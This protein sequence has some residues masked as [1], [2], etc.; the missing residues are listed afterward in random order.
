MGQEKIIYVC[1]DAV[2]ETSEAVAR[3]AMRQF[4]AGEVKLKRYGHIKSEEEIAAIVKEAAATGGFI[5]FTLVQPELR[6]MMKEE[7]QR[8]G[9]RVVDVMGPMMQ[10]YIDTF[11]GFPKRQPGLL[12]AL[13]EDYF[14][15]IEA[16]EFAVKYDDGKD[17]RGL[18][19]AQ[20]VL[21]GVSRTSKTPL[22]IFL[23]HK[24]IKVANFPLIPEVKVPPELVPV[25]GRLIV[26]L[27][28]QPEH[29]IKVR[30][31][32]L[33]TMGLPP[34]SQYAS[35]ARIDEE[36]SYAAKVM[37]SLDCRII[38]VTDRAIEETAGIVS[39]WLN[40]INR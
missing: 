27:T 10:A 3:A 23:A 33:K 16:I 30:K 40:E 24:G 39:A 1:S 34:V 5:A 14:E 20:V 21:V 17:A 25:P 35:I 28:M 8:C 38:D 19:Q 9:V 4:P 2:G 13:D 6:E 29:M 18:Q 32:R 37:Q 31:E 36:L 15:R 26:G 12:H 7:A 22:S 11:N